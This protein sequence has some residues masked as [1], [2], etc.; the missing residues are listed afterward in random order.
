MDKAVS[1]VD[2]E[3][4][5]AELRAA[6]VF[7]HRELRNWAKLAVLVAVL[8]LAYVGVALGSGWTRLALVPVVAV[9]ATL[10]TLIGH[11]GSHGSF[12]PRSARNRLLA[13]LTLPLLAGISSLY[14]K[15]KHDGLHHNN[16]NVAIKDPDVDLWP[17]AT[18]RADYERAAPLQ[19]WYQ[20]HLQAYLFWPSTLALATTMRVPSYAHLVRRLRADKGP[21]RVALIDAGCLI[22]HYALW[23]LVPSLL[24]GALPALALYVAIWALS[25]LML[26]AVFAPAHIGMPVMTGRHRGLRHELETTRNVRAPRWLAFFYV[27]LD[28]QIEHHIFPLIPHQNLPRAGQIM[29]RWCAEVGLP[30]H[31]AGVAEGL[32]SATAFLRDAWQI[33]ASS[34]QGGAPRPSSPTAAEAAEGPPAGGA[35][36]LTLAPLSSAFESRAAARTPVPLIAGQP[37]Q[38]SGRCRRNLA[39]AW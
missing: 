6:G 22:A 12:S 24:W 15:H 33:D 31:E 25:G 13:Y 28:Y 17:M 23:L 14:W 38:T 9:A 1:R 27:G 20:R 3:R 4:L 36:E 19:R 35:L 7:E 5:R 32:A 10:A 29:R 18:T 2:Q 8:V 30:Y 34:T 37:S 21:Q 26:A 11:D 39:Q 16:A